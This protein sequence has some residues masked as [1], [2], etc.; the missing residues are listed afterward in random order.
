ME[1]CSLELLFW[2]LHIS[3]IILFPATLKGVGSLGLIFLLGSCFVFT[4]FMNICLMQAEEAHR[5]KSS[6]KEGS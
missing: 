1:E 2:R 3:T 5:N 4:Y 6:L